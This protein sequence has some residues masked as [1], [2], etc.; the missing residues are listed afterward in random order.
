MENETIIKYHTDFGDHQT[1][2]A[3][4]VCNIRNKNLARYKREDDHG[5]YLA[6]D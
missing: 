5:D 1:I 4:F 6:F 2:Q 3:G